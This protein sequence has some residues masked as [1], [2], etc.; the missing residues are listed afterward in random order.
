MS[1]IEAFY[2][3]HAENEWTRL[4]R[5]RTEFAVTMRALVE[6]LPKPPARILDVG[7]GPGRYAIALAG[8]GHQ[9]TLL[10]LSANLLAVARERAAEARVTLDDYVH[11]NALDLTAFG[12]D[13]FDAVLLMG[14]L[15]HL[16]TGADRRRA[17][18]QAARV[19]RPG[20]LLFASFISRYA[21]FRDVAKYE[22]EWLVQHAEEATKLLRAGTLPSPEGFTDAHFAHP[23]E[24]R[25]LFRATGLPVLEV[26]ACEGLISMIEDKINETTGEVW[27][28]WVDLNYRLGKDPSVHGAAEHLL[29]VVRKPRAQKP[30]ARKAAPHKTAARKPA[31]RKK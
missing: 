8:R 9:V 13:S 26:I 4:E 16:L 14:P 21:P 10:D 3:S 17:V 19:L 31:K 18:R 22:P 30:A 24:I 12:R 2:D 25:P 7:G 20:G 15:Y 5:H 29:A 28:A 23:S 6:H 11:G 27:E 1:R